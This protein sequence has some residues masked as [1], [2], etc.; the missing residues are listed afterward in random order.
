MDKIL[1]LHFSTCLLM[2]GLIW[3]VQFVHYPSFKYASSAKF[4]SFCEFH[5]KSI[6][7]IV[8][9]LM[10]VELVTGAYL[11]ISGPNFIHALNFSFIILTW[12]STFILSMPLHQKLAK[13]YDITTINN[14]VMTNW[15]RTL[16]WTG[17]SVLLFYYLFTTMGL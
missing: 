17:R 9:P 8:M 3:V 1:L 15:P 16:F 13:D 5:V 14:L 7:F 10:I 11:F 2:S 12:I 4:K 6:S